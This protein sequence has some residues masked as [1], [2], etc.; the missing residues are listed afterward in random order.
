MPS[1]PDEGEI[2]EPLPLL[3]GDPAHTEAKC[4]REFVVLT[5]LL[6]SCVAQALR[7]R[8][9][10]CDIQYFPE[11]S[12][13]THPSPAPLPM[14]RKAKP[15]VAFAPFQAAPLCVKLYGEGAPWGTR[16][17]PAARATAIRRAWGDAKGRARHAHGA[18]DIIAAAGGLKVYTVSGSWCPDASRCLGT[19]IRPMGDRT[20]PRRTG[21][22]ETMA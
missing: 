18:I 11:F 21:R 12:S 7:R 13:C 9:G 3:F 19:S 10:G 14:R 2:F 22:M 20:S 6:V 16:K 5:G 1:L 4:G 8:G 15:C 17:L